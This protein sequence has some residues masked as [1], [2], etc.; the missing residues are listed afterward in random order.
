MQE[1][2][3]SR[4]KQRETQL[5]AHL[6]DQRTSLLAEKQ[7]VEQSL[8]REMEKALEE[9]DKELEERLVKQKVSTPSVSCI[10][11]GLHTP[12]GVEK[13]LEEGANKTR[14]LIA[15]IVRLCL[16]C[17]LPRQLGRN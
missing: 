9:K 8:Q 12:Q 6:E 3:E 16:G 15:C 11:P 7:K 10:M 13:A 14:C 1:E 4:L 5:T 2:L 17:I